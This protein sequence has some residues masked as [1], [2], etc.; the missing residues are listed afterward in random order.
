MDI[1]ELKSDS[2][3]SKFSGPELA[4]QRNTAI[5]IEKLASLSGTNINNWNMEPFLKENERLPTDKNKINQVFFSLKENPVIN[6]DDE[7]MTEEQKRILHKTFGCH[8][9]TSLKAKLASHERSA[10]NYSHEA[11]NQHKLAMRINKELLSAMAGRNTSDEKMYELLSQGFWEVHRYPDEAEATLILKTVNEVII[12]YINED[13]GV[14]QQ[15]NFGRMR[16]R[17]REDG[18]VKVY[19]KQEDN[20]DKFIVDDGHCHPHVGNGGGVCTGELS[21]EFD[22]AVGERD[23]SKI[24]IIVQKVLLSY[25]PEDAYRQIT[26]YEFAKMSHEKGF[27]RSRCNSYWGLYE[28]WLE[29][30]ELRD[31]SKNERYL[32]AEELKKQIEDG[33]Q[34]H[35]F[36]S[37]ELRTVR[38]EMELNTGI[39]HGSRSDERYGQVV[40]NAGGIV[41]RG[42]EIRDWLVNRNDARAEA[43]F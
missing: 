29:T 13:H 36:S 39:T 6:L 37:T 40:Y 26:H 15:F 9:E 38:R 22:R 31:P 32:T 33:P 30:D 8:D 14:K 1:I 3:L 4:K 34:H 5:Y 7:K 11:A 21:K 35:S 19:I 2:Y 20:K 41:L 43:P 24:A 25:N 12:T 10:K 23:F 42:T 16:L 27:D 17:L 18:H 28:H